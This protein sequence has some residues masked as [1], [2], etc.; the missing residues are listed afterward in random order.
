MAL[1]KVYMYTQTDYHPRPLSFIVRHRNTLWTPHNTSK[2]AQHPP[3]NCTHVC[4]LTQH[5]PCSTRHVDNWWCGVASSWANFQVIGVE[6][7]SFLFFI[8]CSLDQTLLLQWK[9]VWTCHGDLPLM[10]G[11]L[12]VRICCHARWVGHPAVYLQS[13]R[14]FRSSSVTSFSWTPFLGIVPLWYIL[15]P[16]HTQTHTSLFVLTPSAPS[17]ASR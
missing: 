16:C 12:Q 1:G 13:N 10:R 15:W 6:C 17:L 3:A 2:P 9:L 14:W 11:C 4:E 5:A 7:V 8:L